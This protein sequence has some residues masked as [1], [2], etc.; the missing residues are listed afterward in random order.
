MISEIYPINL[1]L[2]IILKIKFHP[3]N[4]YLNKVY[5]HIEVLNKPTLQK[6]KMNCDDIIDKQL[7]EFPM[8]E[9]VWHISL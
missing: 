8:V 3:I 1:Y 4:F 2:K 6:V 9:D 5:M 7:F